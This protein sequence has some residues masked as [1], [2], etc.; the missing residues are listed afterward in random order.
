[1]ILMR[2]KTIIT[3]NRGIW[4]TAENKPAR[5][6]NPGLQNSIWSPK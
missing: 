4:I 5:Y 1:M 3:M 6:D 2:T